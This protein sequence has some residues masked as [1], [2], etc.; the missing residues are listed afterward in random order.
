MPSHRYLVLAPLNAALL[1][2][3]LA[4]GTAPARATPFTIIGAST[5]A[6]TLGNGQTGT[7]AP[8]AS[9]GVAGSTVAVTV[10][11]SNATLNN[12]GVIAQTGSGRAIRDN[13]GVANLVINNGSRD[14][15]SAVIRT[16]DADV[17][18]MNVAGA[19]VKLN[20]YGSLVSQNASAG[21]AQAVDFAAVTG[22]NVVNNYAGALLQARE[23]DAVRP[24][25]GGIVYNAGTIRATTISGSGSDGI[26]GQNNSGIRITNDGGGLIDGGRHGITGGQAAAADAF[27]LS[28]TNNAGAVIRGN[29]GSGINIDGLNARQLLTVINHGTILGNGISGD[30]DGID[31]DGLA[32]ITNT[33]IIRS[34][35]AFNPTPAGL[36]YSEGIT[37]GGG[38]IV[39][40]GTI[41]GLVAA[42]NANA[43][44]R[45]ITLAGN[46]I[47][48]GA[49]AGTREGLYGN[50]T[51][52]NRAGG[53]IRGQSDSAIV[54]Q[55]AASGFTVTIDN[56]AG[57]V[58]RG[59][60]ATTAAIMGG[61]D[62]TVI[63]NAG[64]ID[65]SSSGKAIQLGGAGGNGLTILGGGARVI[66]AID[67]GAGRGNTMLVD[68]GTG[69]RFTYAGAIADFDSVEFRSGVTTLSGQSSYTGATVLGGGTL[70]LMGDER[71]AA[72]SALVLAGGTLDLTGA[73][74]Q[75]FASLSLLDDSTIDFGHG[76]LTF[77]GLGTVAGGK[78]LALAEAL[79]TSGYL[80]RFLG[81][82][83]G[84]AD[85]LA[86]LRAAGSGDVRITSS[87]DGVYTNVLASGEVPEPAGLALMLGG[88]AMMA[89]LLRRVA[90]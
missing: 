67:G 33:G 87:F 24:G 20:N 15:G 85:F 81:D 29:N 84:N 61:A 49:L 6:Q 68:A 77:G 90:R 8:G 44:G 21:G 40:A 18:Q 83:A 72:A 26:D 70:A 31:V 27:A 35:N 74:S 53:L 45:G 39:N 10:D 5:A 23:A 13:T 46:D 41:E 54:A 16:A 66:G 25:A 73:G 76:R 47:A 38:V 82:Y 51:I 34:T 62:R 57:A 1:T 60:G 52:E 56:H 3:M 11:G 50:A 71:I 69:N 58:I 88:L 12:G 30:G 63:A 37:A 7:V 86:L 48:G 65:G 59:G 43:V 28:V 19:S 9:L 2:A 22:A 80:M 64:V 4:L 89:A 17:V 75:T 78:T 36:A 55:G 14:N 32:S 42:G 79:A